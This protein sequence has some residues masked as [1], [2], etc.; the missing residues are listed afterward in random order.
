[1]KRLLKN[2]LRH[3]TTNGLTVEE[4]DLCF[5]VL[6]RVLTGEEKRELVKRLERKQNV[7]TGE[8]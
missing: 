4:L 7:G 5:E 6:L 1:M 8:E 3:G 2:V